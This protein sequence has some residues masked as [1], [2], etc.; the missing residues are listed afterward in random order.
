[1]TT[2]YATTWLGAAEVVEML[3][4]SRSKVQSMAKAGVVPTY[5]FERSYSFAKDQVES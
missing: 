1:M 2:T 3:S 5:R 4:I